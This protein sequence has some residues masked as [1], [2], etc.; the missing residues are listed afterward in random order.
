MFV[1]SFKPEMYQATGARLIE[2]FNHYCRGMYLVAC[3]E[4]FEELPASPPS[5][6]VEYID[7]TNDPV[8]TRWL[9]VNRAIIPQHLGGTLPK[10]TCLVSGFGIDEEHQKGCR[11]GW[12]NRNAARWF[13]KIVSLNRVAAC[14]PHSYLI[15]IDSDCRFKKPLPNDVALSWFDNN[16]GFYCKSSMRTVLESGVLGINLNKR[17]GDF[18]QAIV[19]RYRSGVFRA[20]PRWDD[21]YQIQQVIDGSKGLSLIDLAPYALSYRAEV[22]GTSPIGVYLEHYRGVHGPVLHI[23]T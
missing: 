13:R 18:L 7:I 15:W 14:Y 16:D 19:E 23:M 12:Y 4:Q 5:S 17:G 20:D 9:D 22:I 2:S 1:T 11:F 21:G 3:A 8:L 10:C 6:Y